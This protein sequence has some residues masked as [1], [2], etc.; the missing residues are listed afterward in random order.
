MLIN[1]FQTEKIRYWIYNRNG[2][3]VFRGDEL[4][5]RYYPQKDIK[6]LWSR[7]AGRCSYPE[8]RID[9]IL[10]GNKSDP[11][12]TIG[13]MA[14]IHA[15]SKAGPRFDPNISKVNGYDNLILLCSTHHAMI[16]KQPKSYP[17]EIL[18]EWKKN[19]EKWVNEK[20]TEKFGSI[21][22]IELEKTVKGILA[23]PVSPAENL[24]L[25]P[26]AQKISKNKLSPRVAQKIK[27]GLIKSKEVGSFVKEMSKTDPSFP[28]KLSNGFVKKYKELRESGL[29]SD[30]LFEA[31]HDYASG[32]FHSFD[33]KA[34]GLAV[35]VYL[36]EIC[37]IFEK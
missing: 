14:H 30:Y 17:A 2:Y 37:E 21:S 4:N 24:T 7:A 6:V 11:V 33:E 18:K 16:D 10:P 32:G 22:F 23:E 19:H 15:C 13:E 12:A 1:L 25:V 26:P 3:I 29:E 36:F 9:L 31:L 5:S 34:A 28:E 8:C 35:L 27:L 20:L